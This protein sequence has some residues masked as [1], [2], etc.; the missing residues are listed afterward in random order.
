MEKLKKTVSEI[1]LYEN[2]IESLIKVVIWI[3]SW[4]GGILVLLGDENKEVLG[5]A[6]FIYMLSLL[7]EF[8]PK[9]MIRHNFG[10]NFYIH[11]YVLL[12]Q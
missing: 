6:Y 10:V 9:Y 2:K 12:C 7:M 8:V 3:I 1:H 11:Y 4:I 5:S